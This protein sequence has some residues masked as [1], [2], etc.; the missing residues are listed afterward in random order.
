MA[1]KS[2]RTSKS[3]KRRPPARRDAG[4]TD[5]DALTLSK[6]EKLARQVFGQVTRGTNPAVEIRTRTLSNVAFNEKR[7]I[8]ELG[9]KTQSR[10]FFNTAM[11]RKFMQ[12]LLVAS[13]CKV[14]LDENKT[15]SI[16]QMFYMTKHTIEGSSENTFED[17]GESDP[18]IED[19]EVGIDALREEL[20]LFANRRGLVVGKLVVNDAGD[21]IDLSRMG[22][23]GW[24]IPSICEP[25]HLNFVG[26]SAEFILCVEKQAVWHRLNEDRFWEK[27][28]CI[29]MTSEGQAARGARRLLQRMATELGL[30]VYVLVDNDPWGLYIYSVLKQGSINLA[31]ESMR[32]AVP[33]VRFLGMSAFDYKKFTMPRAAEIK[34]TKED[35]ARAEQMKAYPWFKH[36][37]WQREIQATL[38]N[39]FKM[40]VDAL[41]T[42][43][44]SFITEQYIPKKLRDRDYL[45]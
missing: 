9:D 2:I 12:T 44:I 3:G 19:L 21:T 35:I 11:A 36:K 38:E 15:I 10:E 29:L 7:K 42:K 37:K 28:N 17:Q 31:Y 30:P 40:E 39:G 13:G 25:D 45:Q 20:H 43:S 1:A 18:I 27:H 23:G 26:N 24:G 14:L 8:I 33:N 32:M 22:R 6:I 5:R 4:A 16:R 41:L 34:L